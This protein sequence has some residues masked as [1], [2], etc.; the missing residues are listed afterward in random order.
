LDRRLSPLGY[1]VAFALALGVA[2][3]A[4]AILSPSVQSLLA[5]L[6]VIPLHRIFTRLTMIGTV[7]LTVWF[8]I[9]QGLARRE[10]LGYAT[11]W[12]VF[13]RRIAIAL[14]AG[15][16]LMTVTLVPLFLLDVRIWNNRL[17]PTAAGVALLG[18]KALLQG[19]VVALIEEN[20]FRGAMQGAIQRAGSIRA[21][22]FAVPVLYSAVH[23]F[24]E[25]VRVPYD[26]VTA[27]SG[28]TIFFGFFKAFADPLR[29]ADAFLALYCVGLLLALVRYRWG[30]LAG[31]LGLHAG[32]VATISVFHRVSAPGPDSQWSFLVGRFDGLVGIWIA[33]LTLI[34]CAIVWW[35]RGNAAPIRTA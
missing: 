10:V 32:F 27:A 1:F 25:A 7:L 19:L 14:A 8:L 9:R 16:V 18:V 15:L 31:S 4:A 29:I 33:F 17:P 24:G 5:P 26:Q 6:S 22:L 3:L 23:F 2:M 34:C 13:L 21:A 11:P 20:F 30:D 28:F 35:T 12:P